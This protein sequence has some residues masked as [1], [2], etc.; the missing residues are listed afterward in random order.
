MGIPLHRIPD[1]RRLYGL[2]A[3]GDS[4]IDFDTGERR[5]AKRGNGWMERVEG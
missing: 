1:I 4:A 3:L 2:D 5:E